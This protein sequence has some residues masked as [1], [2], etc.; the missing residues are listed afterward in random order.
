[1]ND[2]RPDAGDGNA[3]P[4][5]VGAMLRSARAVSGLSQRELAR[6]SG[7]S[8]STVARAETDAGGTRTTVRT[9]MLLLASCGIGLVAEGSSGRLLP[10]ADPERDD[11]GRRFPPHLDPYPP[12]GR[13]EWWAPNVL[14]QCIVDS[15]VPWPARTFA[16]DR[17][18]RSERR[19]VLDQPWDARFWEHSV[20]LAP[21]LVVH[22]V[23][24]RRRSI[25]DRTGQWTQT[26]PSPT[27][28]R[29]YGWR[30]VEGPT[31]RRRR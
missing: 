25:F 8:K 13:D 5:D 10:D 27:D 1:M 19:A 18:R 12:L 6:A 30:W 14:Y 22:P 2:D 31:E 7:L 29:R 9:L 23:L 20:D 11:G 3:K 26:A 28:L 17:R 24:S 15:L 16:L 4:W 21:P